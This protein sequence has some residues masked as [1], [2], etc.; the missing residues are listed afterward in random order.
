MEESRQHVS[1][2]T[3]AAGAAWAIPAVAVVGS[4]PAHAAS[5]RKDPGI[6]GWVRNT[7]N[8]LGRCGWSLEVDSTVTRGATPDGAPWGLYIYDVEDGNTFTEAKLVYW[9]IGNQTASWSTLSGH[10]TC[11]NGPDRGTP[12]TK[13]DGFLYTP[14]TWTYTCGINAAARGE[15]SDGVERLYLGNFH[16]K[17]TFTQPTQPRDHC[18]DVTY[19][20]Q[21]FV[22]IDPDGSG[23][24]PASE[25]TFER[26]NGTRG[27]YTAGNRAMGARSTSPEES[28]HELPS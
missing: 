2:R 1:R 8:S 3:L 24:L 14:Y 19:W 16:V 21:R 4:A 22:T 26:R 9:I 17:A 7:P 13:A 20:T 18:R 15:D 28:G 10:S 25:R 27:P 23:P 11:W 6:N 5:L 12:R